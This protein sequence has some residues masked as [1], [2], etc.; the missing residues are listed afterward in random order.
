MT[1]Q[2]FINEYAYT[3]PV[4]VRDSTNIDL[5]RA[6]ASKSSLLSSYGHTTVTLSSANTYSYDKKEI[7]F[8]EYCDKHTGPQGIHTLGNGIVYRKKLKNQYNV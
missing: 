2:E 8:K 7:T 5:F 3:K 4:I 1:Q 6:L